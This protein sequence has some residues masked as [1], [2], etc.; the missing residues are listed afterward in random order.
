[1]Y[2]HLNNQY[3]SFSQYFIVVIVIKTLIVSGSG[4]FEVS[5]MKVTSSAA[6]RE[7]TP[8]IASGTYG[9]CTMRGAMGKKGSI[10]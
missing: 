6:S 9:W 1:M 5:G 2:M 4:V 10:I 8:K 7:I 3:L